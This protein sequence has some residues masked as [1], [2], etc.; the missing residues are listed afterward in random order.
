MRK[1][2]H[3]ALCFSPVGDTFRV[4]AR[5]FPA[6]VSCTQIDWF[7]SWSQEALVAVAQRFLGDNHSVTHRLKQMIAEAQHTMQLREGDMRATVTEE[8]NRQAM[9]KEFSG[10]LGAACG[11]C[12]A[13][14]GERSTRRRHLARRD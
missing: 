3:V 8:R 5:Q 14:E 10:G 4:R 7:H 13:G 11:G 2:L 6:L 9:L 1:Y 12:S